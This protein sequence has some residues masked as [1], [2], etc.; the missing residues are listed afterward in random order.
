MLWDFKLHGIAFNV[1]YKTGTAEA[2]AFFAGEDEANNALAFEQ[3]SNE[4]KEGRVQRVATT[5]CVFGST[6]AGKGYTLTSDR[7]F[8]PV[9]GATY[10]IEF[11]EVTISGKHGFASAFI[12]A[13]GADPSQWVDLA[14]GEPLDAELRAYAVQAYRRIP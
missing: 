4:V 9:L 12:R 3:V 13:D 6:V 5:T 14:S 2:D 10:D 11:G 8:V 1:P 7:L